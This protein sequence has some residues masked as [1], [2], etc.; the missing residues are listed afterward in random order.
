MEL[1]KENLQPYHD[2]SQMCHKQF[3]NVRNV[4]FHEVSNFRALART[5]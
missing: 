2:H 4:L 3:M 5:C 1:C